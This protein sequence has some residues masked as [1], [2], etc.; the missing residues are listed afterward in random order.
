MTTETWS[1]RSAP[2]PARKHLASRLLLLAAVLGVL[3]LWVGP[4]RTLKISPSPSTLSVPGLAA[5]LTAL[6]GVTPCSKFQ[7]VWVAV[8]GRRTVWAC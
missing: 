3:M 1:G 8:S 4:A 7:F 6:R 2:T 5:S